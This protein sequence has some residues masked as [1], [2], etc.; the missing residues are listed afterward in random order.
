M[1]NHFKSAAAYSKSSKWFFG[2]SESEWF[3]ELKDQFQYGLEISYDL[4]GSRVYK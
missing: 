4:S 1:C 3:Q 2:K